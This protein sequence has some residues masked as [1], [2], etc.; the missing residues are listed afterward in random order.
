[1]L[2]KQSDKTLTYLELQDNIRNYLYQQKLSQR[3]EQYLDRVR[4]K[5]FVKR[6]GQTQTPL[7]APFEDSPHESGGG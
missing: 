2:A 4:G 1:V 7:Q 5:V 6:F 3:L